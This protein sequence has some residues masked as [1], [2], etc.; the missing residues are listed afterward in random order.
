MEASEE[1]PLPQPATTDDLVE[2]DEE[3]YDATSRVF[4][5]LLLYN[6]NSEEPCN[7]LSALLL[8]FEKQLLKQFNAISTE[9]KNVSFW[10]D[11][12]IPLSEYSRLRALGSMQR[13]GQLAVQALASYKIFS[14]SASHE[15]TT[16]LLHTALT[17]SYLI[18]MKEVE[19]LE[20]AHPPCRKC[21]PYH[22][23]WMQTFLRDDRSPQ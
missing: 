8:C 6:A 11:I 17:S 1:E 5:F 12:S 13:A 15:K 10:T 22:P 16:K 4:T 2:K 21:F 19:K 14:Y 9:L 18:A 7:R 23:V 3:W 20:I